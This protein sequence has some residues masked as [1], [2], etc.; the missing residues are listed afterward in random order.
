LTDGHETAGCD[1]SAKIAWDDVEL[2]EEPEIAFAFLDCL[3]FGNV[4]ADVS[5]LL[6]D[7]LRS[8]LRED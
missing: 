2:L 1:E 6:L 3:R 7:L 4:G 5:D 8:S